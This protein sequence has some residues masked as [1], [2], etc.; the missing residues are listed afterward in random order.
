LPERVP[1]R[2]LPSADR[3]DPDCLIHLAGVAA[4]ALGVV[5]ISDLTDYQ[6]LPNFGSGRNRASLTADDAA[7]AAG[8]VPVAIE[9]RT[10]PAKPAWAD[11]SSGAGLTTPRARPRTTRPPPG[12]VVPPFD[13]RRSAPQRTQPDLTIGSRPQAYGP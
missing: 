8:L 6:R 11:P 12:T 13:S 4:K 9:S 10:G 1:P 3:S 2:R 7:V 5:T